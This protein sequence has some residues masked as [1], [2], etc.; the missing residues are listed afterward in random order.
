MFLFA[1]RLVNI[2]YSRSNR[3]FGDGVEY[4]TVNL[5]AYSV[6]VGFMASLLRS[7]AADYTRYYVVLDDTRLKVVQCD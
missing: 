3:V 1:L 6:P 4:R 2:T 7:Q 5:T